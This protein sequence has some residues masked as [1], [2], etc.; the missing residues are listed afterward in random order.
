MLKHASEID[1]YSIGATDG[2]IGKITDFLFDDRTWLVRWVVVDTGQFLS[3]Q[4][5]LLPT[6]ALSHVNHIANQFAV[7]LT[8]GQVEDSPSID[9]D[10]PVSRLMETSLFD[11]YGWTPYW[12]DGFYMGGYGYGG[13][14]IA[15]AGLGLTPQIRKPDPFLE[16]HADRRLHSVREVTGYHVHASDGQ[17]GH[18]D[19]FLL[20]DEDWSVHYLVVDTQNWWPGKKVLIS[21]RS[22]QSVDWSLRSVMLSIARQGIKDSPAYDGSQAVDRA[23]EYAYHG[24]YDHLP[25]AEPV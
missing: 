16:A 2:P 12:S 22:V 18:V 20:E 4:K 23:Y 8:K 14:V 17:V 25:V 13:G 5:V 3:P 24:Y 11:Y 21:P 1:G 7:R 9:T 19:D 10:V 15:P 6:S